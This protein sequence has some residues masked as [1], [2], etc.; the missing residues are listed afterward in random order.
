MWMGFLFV[1]LFVF[2]FVFLFVCFREGGEWGGKGKGFISSSIF[3]DKC[4]VLTIL[5]IMI[6]QWGAGFIMIAPQFSE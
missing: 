6:V 1:C 4:I 2:A 5:Y 3:G